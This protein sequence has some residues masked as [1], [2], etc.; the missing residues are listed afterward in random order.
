MTTDITTTPTAGSPLP[1]TTTFTPAPECLEDLWRLNSEWSGVY[2]YF[3][4]LGPDNTEKCLPSGWDSTVYYSPGLACPSGFLTGSTSVSDG[5]T[6]ATCCPVY[7]KSRWTFVQRTPGDDAKPWHTFESCYYNM[8]ADAEYTITNT[9]DGS[10][11]TSATAGSMTSG[12]GWNAYGL[13]IRWRA[14][15]LSSAPAT[16]SASATETET[17]P[18]GTSEESSGLSTGAKAGIGIG[19]GVGGLLAI[20]AVGFLIL[21]G[22]KR[23]GEDSGDLSG[24]NGDLCPGG[25]VQH[26]LYGSGSPM[27]QHHDHELDSNPVY[28]KGGFQGA[29]SPLR[30]PVEPA[31]LEGP[32]IR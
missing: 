5:E 19:V 3:A 4:N 32:S 16:A 2:T 30:E 6:I 20:L 11:F 14:S 8:T 22:R 18:Q 29:R 10:T 23:R 12:D 25:P 21:R 13:E 7:T 15:D 26:E 28:E 31:E 24:T 1:L 17:T 9:D 27:L